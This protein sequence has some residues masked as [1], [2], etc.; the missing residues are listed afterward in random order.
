MLH[1]R[2]SLN[3]SFSRAVVVVVVVAVV[4]VGVVAAAA[5]AGGSGD[6]G[7]GGGVGLILLAHGVVVVADPVVANFF[8]A[9]VVA[10]VAAV[11]EWC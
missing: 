3:V 4:G 7:G 2:F 1:T 6:G 10:V 8:A 5:A 9:S 11:C